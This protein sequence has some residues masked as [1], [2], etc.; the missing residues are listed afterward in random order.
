MQVSLQEQED[1]E[2]WKLCT[3][4]KV[5]AVAWTKVIPVATERKGQT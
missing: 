4:K 5:L 1:L 3:S 2:A